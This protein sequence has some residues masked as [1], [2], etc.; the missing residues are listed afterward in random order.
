MGNPLSNEAN[1]PLSEK[2]RYRPYDQANFVL[3]PGGSRDFV[4]LRKHG[5]ALWA[6]VTMSNPNL[7]CTVKLETGT[8]EYSNTFT[9]TNLMAANLVAP[10][11]S[12][13]WVSRFDVINNVYCVMFTPSQWWPFYRRINIV[14]TNNTV[15][16]ITVFR[17]SLLAIEFIDSV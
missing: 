13:W 7:S 4:D 11:P 14:L 12:G 3:Q 6:G 16:P 1:L 2:W 9:C 15:T 8:E 10:T 5:W 17:A